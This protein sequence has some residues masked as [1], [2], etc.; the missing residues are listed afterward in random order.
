MRPPRGGAFIAFVSGE[1]RLSFAC[2][3][4]RM[5]LGLDT[6]LTDPQKL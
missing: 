2:G 5:T 6:P 4:Q 1:W 3:G